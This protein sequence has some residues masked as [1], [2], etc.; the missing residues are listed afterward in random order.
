M[1]DQ[2][3]DRA[4]IGYL[5]KPISDDF[6][7]AQSQFDRTIREVVMQILGG[8]AADTSEALAPQNVCWNS[9]FELVPSSPAAMTVQVNAGLA[10]QYLTSGTATDIGVP[11]LIGVDDLATYRPLLLTTPQVFSVPSVS[12]P[13]NRI[14]IIEVRADRQ[15]IDSLTRRQLDPVTGSF[16]PHNYYKTLTH[17]INGLTG[18]VAAPAVSTAPISYVTGVAA[19]APTAPTVTSGYFKL[20]EIVVSNTTT[21][22]TVAE[23]IDRRK[24][25][26]PGG[27]LAGNFRLRVQY[28]AGTPI[29]TWRSVCLPPGVQIAAG[30]QPGAAANRAFVRIYLIAGGVTEF[31]GIT[32]GTNYAASPSGLLVS[33]M[34]PSAVST[35]YIVTADATLKAAILAATPSTVVA[36]GQPVVVIDHKSTYSSAIGV[37]DATNSFL[38]DIEIQGN[39]ALSY[40]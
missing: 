6:N 14:D 37:F 23:I 3:F 32:K 11:D 18:T 26:A 25:A 28:N 2:V 34:R 33:D 12:V 30:I 22:I 19:G 9:G 21:T 39:V 38:D 8:R 27:V 31:A 15:L 1:A 10:W 20:A 17:L 36:V 13:N 4:P 40:L 5:E 35:D 7:R 29:Y 16:D 24:L